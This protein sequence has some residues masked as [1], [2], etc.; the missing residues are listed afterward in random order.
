MTSVTS[1]SQADKHYKLGEGINIEVTFDG[2]GT[3]SGGDLLVTH[4][5][6]TTPFEIS[7]MS[8]NVAEGEYLVAAG[9][10]SDWL[11]SPSSRVPLDVTTIAL[12]L[13][14]SILDSAGNPITVFSIPASNNFVDSKPGIV[15]DGIV[16]ADFTV[17]TCSTVTEPVRSGFWNGVNT[18]LEVKVLVANDTS[19][20][21]GKV[22]IRGKIPP[23]AFGNLGEAYTILLTDLTDSVTITIEDAGTVDPDFE[24]I[25]GFAENATVSISAIITD[26]AGNATYGTTSATRLVV[27]Q[28]LPETGGVTGGITDLVPDVPTN[29][30]IS[31]AIDGYWNPVSYTHLT[32]PTNREV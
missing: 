11:V 14:A 5:A 13:G 19:L 20:V 7:S 26:K 4:N 29:S 12:D 31:V 17:G 9:D 15:V 3:L 32:L 30:S 6:S 1:S 21:G 23:T 18:A 25:S 8:N 22:Q 2:A 10:E 24:E 28:T 27:D 16:P